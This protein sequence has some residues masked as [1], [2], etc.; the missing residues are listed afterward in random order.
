ML[1]GIVC[2][3]KALAFFKA[4]SQVVDNGWSSMVSS[5]SG[6]KFKMVF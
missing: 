2:S 6:S 5:K 1:L 3:G 4:I